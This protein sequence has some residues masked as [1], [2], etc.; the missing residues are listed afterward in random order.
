M[1]V[2]SDFTSKG[3]PGFAKRH[4]HAVNIVA[5]ETDIQRLVLRAVEVKA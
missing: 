5:A 2:P 3:M 4:A 1:E